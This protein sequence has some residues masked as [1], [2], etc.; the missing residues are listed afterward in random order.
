M[1]SPISPL[2]LCAQIRTHISFFFE[3]EHRG[4]HHLLR[5]L[6]TN[7]CRDRTIRFDRPTIDEFNNRSDE[8]QSALDGPRQ[9]ALH[10]THRWPV[11]DMQKVTSGIAQL[12]RVAAEGIFRSRALSGKGCLA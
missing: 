11:V 7:N 8:F 2:Q 3:R 1:L 4:E 12:N 9:L 5:D 6:R 10:C